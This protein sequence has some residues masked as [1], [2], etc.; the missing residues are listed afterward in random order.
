MILYAGHHGIIVRHNLA[1]QGMIVPYITENRTDAII[2]GVYFIKRYIPFTNDSFPHQK[3]GCYS[4]AQFI[5]IFWI[6][7]TPGSRNIPLIPILHN[8]P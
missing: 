2:S 5:R 4:M 8:P 3:L 7:R 1:A 6:L